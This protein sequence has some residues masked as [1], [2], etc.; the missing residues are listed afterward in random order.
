MYYQ[1]YEDYMR[2]VLGYANNERNY[3]YDSYYPRVEQTQYD[4]GLEDLYPDI[5]R[6]INPVV[7]DVCS[8]NRNKQITEEL[9]RTM[10]DEVYNNVEGNSNLQVNVQVRTELKNGDVRNPNAKLKEEPTSE[11]RQRNFLLND[12]IRILILRNLLRR[13]PPVRPPFPGARP[14]FPGHR[15]DTSPYSG[16]SVPPYA[17]MM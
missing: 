15:A 8:K 14:P 17:P 9:V 2:S 3:T 10:T 1:N 5:Y 13:R 4:D 6:I 11:T 7:E 16:G 12:L